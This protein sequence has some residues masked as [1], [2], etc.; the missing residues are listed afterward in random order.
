V[1]VTDTGVPKSC[2]QFVKL[3]YITLEINVVNT[4]KIKGCILKN[5]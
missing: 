4:C 2:M 5:W 1:K 3:P